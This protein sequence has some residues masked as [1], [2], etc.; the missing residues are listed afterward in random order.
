MKQE[1]TYCGLPARDLP[2]IGTV[3][4]IVAGASLGGIA[5][6]L[7]AARL[8]VN[9][10]VVSYQPYLGEDIC[11]SYWHLFEDVT[12]DHPL[13][14]QLFPEGMARTPF[15]VKKVL[16]NQLIDHDVS[17]LYASYVT[18]VL[19]DEQHT[20]AGIAITN[21]SGQQ[22]IRGKA[23]ID[24][25][26]DA[27]VARMAGACFQ[28]H[29][30]DGS[31]SFHFVTAG[32]H[33]R[34]AGA[35]K[36][37]LPLAPEQDQ[38]A[39][40]AYAYTFSKTVQD[41]S[42][43]A[44]CALE[45][46]NRGDVWDED[47]RDAADLLFC[48]PPFKIKGQQP[49]PDDLTC[50]SR[51][52]LAAFMPE[53]TRGIFLSGS[54]ADLSRT[55]AQALTDPE[56]IILL[57][58]R[59]GEAA[60]GMAQTQ[61]LPEL[62]YRPASKPAA[63]MAGELRVETAPVRPAVEDGSFR[64]GQSFIPVVASYDVVVVGGG[65]AGANAGISTARHGARTL[66]AEYLHGLG[67]T[68]TMGRIG[69]Y[70]DGYR[71]G[72]TREIDEGVRNMAPPEHPRQKNQDGQ[73][74]IDWKT[75]WYRRQICEAGGDIWFGAMGCGALVDA[76]RVKGVLLATP[77]GLVV[78][79]AHTVIDATGSG[80]IA[81]AAGAAY[82]NADE[83]YLAVQ[84]AGLPYINLDDRNVN[85]D[86]TFIDDRDVYDI[87]RLFVAGKAKYSSVYDIGK[88]PQTRERRR[89]VGEHV[90]SVLDV[91]NHRRY[92]DTLSFHKSSFDT[93][94]YTIDPYFTL[95]PPEKRHVVYDA[96]VPLSSLLPKGL[97]HILV[98]GLG[99]S[100][101]RDAMPVIRMQP[102]LQNQGYSVGYLS[103]LAVREG[104]SVR[105]VDIKNVQ[106]H[107]VSK[108]ILPERVL[109][110]TDHM[111]YPDEQLRQAAARLPQDFSGLS[112]LLTQPEKTRSLLAQAYAQSEQDQDK[113]VYAQ[114][115]CML[116]D[117]RGV[118]D[119]IGLVRA[120]AQWD[121]G[122]DY[123]GMGQFG[124]CM[125]KLDSLIIA[126]GEAKDPAA[127]PVILE[128]ARQLAPSDALSHF[129]A[130]AL[131]CESIGSPAAAPVLA[132]LLAMDGVSGHAVTSLRQARESVV[133]S[134]VDVTIRNNV[135]REIHLARALFRCGDVEQT[136][137]R[138]LQQYARD[139]HGYYARHARQLLFKSD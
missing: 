139:W 9:V 35:E 102:C 64:L 56:N 55:T 10:F 66:V 133:P 73:A 84:G 29:P 76:G 59:I 92:P 36:H 63:L 26:R 13:L 78:V 70:W 60:A 32:N 127:L 41:W 88:L 39:I 91:V 5:A 98:V 18:E 16:E 43:P 118:Q 94:G 67:G 48:I 14:A 44:L 65:T 99:A 83:Q 105:E 101:H 1:M 138:V 79:T 8:G 106:K 6:A 75:E 72:F 30:S 34:P 134:T 31:H 108:G 24:A 49:C 109:T 113:A 103:A 129:R 95:S 122:W 93:H 3:D 125:S 23:I 137:A 53:R 27:S 128:K 62:S 69:V 132:D 71:E 111:P 50:V 25:T 89:I 37:K 28:D 7:S 112:L 52:P 54:C 115:L 2:V 131:A 46:Q 38:Q 85:T 22:V 107:L 68:Q 80:D 61:A 124:P 33:T 81:I 74:N 90:I 77:Q 116:G 20:P 130:V 86:W 58:D 51:L 123:T 97:D 136:G 121:E 96:D 21:R 120:C 11:G 57:G 87:T 100:A 15:H 114:V 19:L 126:L 17:F 82:Q 42:F 135:L 47:Q 4:L 110:D 117:S 40:T 119:V 104:C 12:G 45:Q